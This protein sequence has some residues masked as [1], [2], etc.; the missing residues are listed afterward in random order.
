MSRFQGNSKVIQGES[1][2]TDET[3]VPDETSTF[4]HINWYKKMRALFPR[5]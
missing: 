5:V 3:G 4:H 1:D 2:E